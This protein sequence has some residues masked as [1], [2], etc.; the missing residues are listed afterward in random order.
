MDDESLE[1]INNLDFEN[2][3][4]EV[5][6]ESEWDY[7]NTK[8]E[9]IYLRQIKEAL[10]KTTIISKT[11]KKGIITDTNTAFEKI[12]GYT[13]EELIG[14]P[15]S[16]VRHPDMPKGFFK[17]LWD[18]IQQGKIFKGVIKNRKKDGNEYYVLANIIPIKNSDGE[19]EEYIAIRQDITKQLKLQKEKES[20]I[21]NAI[22]SLYKKIHSPAYYINKYTNLICEESKKENPNISQ[23]KKY[24]KIIKKEAYILNLTDRILKFLLDIKDHNYKTDIQKVNIYI[25]V[26]KIA[27]KLNAY[28][29]TDYKI[30]IKNNLNSPADFIIETDLKTLKMII[31]IILTNLFLESKKIFILFE[32]N[33]NH[34]KIIFCFKE[35]N[36]ILKEFCNGLNENNYKNSIETYLLKRLSGKIKSKIETGKKEIILTVLNKK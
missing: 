9:I 32:N 6:I 29:N 25:L 17:K 22:S 5:E 26:K 8:E 27:K 2:E 21:N 16:I 30:K 19:I 12:S 10:D 20:Y 11:D 33:K 7:E 1:K 3:L 18:T 34:K 31:E 24:I 13:K 15:H 36:Y 28:F 14:K 4:E 23:I 35:A